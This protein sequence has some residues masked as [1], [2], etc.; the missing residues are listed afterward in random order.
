MLKKLIAIT[1]VTSAS[2][3]SAMDTN[4]TRSTRSTLPI[5]GVYQPSVRDILEDYPAFHRAT[6]E[7]RNIQKSQIIG[8]I[9]PPVTNSSGT[10]LYKAEYVDPKDQTSWDLIAGKTKDGAV[11]ARLEKRGRDNIEIK[12]AQE[13]YDYIVK[14][15]L[16]RRGK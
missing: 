3:I 14:R 9:K 7:Y 12:N 13:I 2:I 16:E 4:T 15:E 8:R 10:Q 5:R 11:F 6:A 1:L